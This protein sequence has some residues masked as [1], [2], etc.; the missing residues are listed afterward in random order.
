MKMQTTQHGMALVF[1][2]VLLLV[3]TILGVLSIRGVG[4]Q[5]RMASNIYDRDLSFQ[6]AEAALLAGEAAVKAS[7][8][9]A[10]LVNCTGGAAN[11]CQPIPTSTFDDDNTNWTDIS[12][13]YKVNTAITAGTP[14]FYIQLMGSSTGTSQM[15]VDN[16]I[17]NSQYGVNT[18][19]IVENYYR[20]TARSSN[21][22][23]VTD[24]AVVV[25]QTTVK[26]GI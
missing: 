18:S 11:V 7:A 8:A 16:N 22:A 4:L 13:D 14:Q 23:A 2:L 5:T 25:L 24:R 26:R 12:A 20:I 3:I 17:N 10:N 6:A 19:T 15:G 1:A 9:P 21:P